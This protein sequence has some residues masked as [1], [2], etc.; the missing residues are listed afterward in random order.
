MSLPL[1][2]RTLM[3]TA[4]AAGIA[5]TSGVAAAPVDAAAGSPFEAAWAIYRRRFVRVAGRVVDTGNKGVSHSEGQGWGM[6]FAEAA[7]DKES[8]RALWEWTRTH[9]RREEDGLLAWRWLPDTDNPVPDRNNAADGDILVAWALARA[10]ARWDDGGF[11]DAALALS[12]AILDHLVVREGPMAP[13]LLPGVQ[14]FRRAE[15]ITLN[16]SYYVF[17]AHPILARLAE[18]AGDTD[19]AML[20]QELSLTGLQVMRRARFGKYG[21]PPDWLLVGADGSV[22]PDPRFPPRF[23][24]DAVRVPLYLA[25]AGLLDAELAAPYRALWST[26]IPGWVDLETDAIAPYEERNGYRSVAELALQVTNLGR[27]PGSTALAAIPGSEDDYYSASLMLLAKLASAEG[28]Q[29]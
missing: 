19:A 6:L 27:E 5:P 21:L 13:V 26:G 15:G 11:R 17:P 9:L 7:G 4:A 3:L 20:W 22:A 14:G 18:T 16:P 28:R 25:W 8:F 24:Y 2:R 10:A 12:R 23:G 29:R 1:S